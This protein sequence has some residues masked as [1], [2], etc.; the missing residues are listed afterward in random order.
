M[1]LG[2]LIGAAGGRITVF[3]IN[4]LKF[5]IDGF[6]MVF[7]LACAF[8]V[9][10]LAATLHG[11]GF[12]AVYVAGIIVSNNEIVHKKM[13][14]RFFDGLAWLSQIGMFITLGLLVFPSKLESVTHTGIIIS[15]FLIFAARPLGVFIALSKSQFNFRE[16]ILISWVGLRGAVPIILAT[17]PLLA[18]IKKADWIFNVVFF[19][20]LSSALLQGWTIPWI[21]RLLKLDAPPEN[22]FSSP[23]EFSSINQLNMKLLNLT[24]PDRDALINKSLVE[25][26]PLKG[27]LV[28][29]ISR[30]E[31]YFVPSGGTTLEKNDIIQVLVPNDKIT[32]LKDFFKS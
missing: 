7:A 3:L 25:I 26:A 2:F 11:S 20:V 21:A 6:Y 5:P 23:I 8:L 16:K 10:G 29:M 22:K 30:K 28:V 18:G 31:E 24:V 13:L 1:G 4:K 15:L 19:I 14:F 9:Y 17:F 12:L 32:E 27:S